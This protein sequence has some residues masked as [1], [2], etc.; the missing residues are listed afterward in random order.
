MEERV[1]IL[2]IDPGSRIMGLGLIDYQKNQAKALH[3]EQVQTKQNDLPA[4]LGVLFQAVSAVITEYQ[5]D[6]VAIE[7]VFLHQHVQAA[8]T[9]GHAR[10]A[11]IA[12]VMH[13]HLPVSEYAPRA[14]KQAV[15]GFG[16]A[17]KNQV[18]MM[19]KALLNL[20][21]LPPADAA[22]ALAVAL[23]HAHMRQSLHN[24]VKG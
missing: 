19:M 20:S 7:A 4:R 12:A 2:G 18:Q 14:I 15:V 8:L 11:I 21:A 6:E 17:Q 5:P 3:F 22:D 16:A 23:T 10:G 9:L 13:H 1:R 24:Q